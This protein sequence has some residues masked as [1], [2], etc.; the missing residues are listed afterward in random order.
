V[1]TAGHDPSQ[2]PAFLLRPI[3]LP[4]KP[5]KRLAVADSDS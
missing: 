4:P 2:L 1:R 3:K 5:A